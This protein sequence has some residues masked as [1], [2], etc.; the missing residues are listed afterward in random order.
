MSLYSVDLRLAGRQKQIRYNED[1]NDKGK[2]LNMFAGTIQIHSHRGLVSEF[3]IPAQNSA[4]SK[5]HFL[6]YKIYCEFQLRL[7]SDW[8]SNKR[9][10]TSGGRKFNF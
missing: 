6:Q 1:S 2:S 10:L 7:S 4:G 8:L 9:A 3:R 5:S